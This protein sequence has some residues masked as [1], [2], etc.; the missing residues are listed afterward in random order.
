[1]P[2]ISFCQLAFGL[3]A[4]ALLTA[5]AACSDPFGQKATVDNVVD[6]VTLYALRN[7]SIRLP[8][9]YSMLNQ[10]P[11]RTDTTLNFDFAFD[12]DSLGQAWIYPAGALG[13]TKSPGIQLLDQLFEDVHSAPNDGYVTDSSR[14]VVEGSVFVARSRVSGAAPCILVSVPRYGKFHVLA[15]DSTARSIRLETLVDLNCGF[16]GLEP[17]IPGS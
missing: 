15:I 12:I 7:T 5:A 6:T 13:L 3:S 14:A 11:A 1:M 4:T 17:G 16:H 2:R 8:S 10:A 9:A